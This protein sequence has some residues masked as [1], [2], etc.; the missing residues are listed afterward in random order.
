MF[1]SEGSRI[2]RATQKHPV[3]KNFKERKETKRRHGVE[4]SGKCVTSTAEQLGDPEDRAS[5]TYKG[6]GKGEDGSLS[7]MAKGEN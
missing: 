3:L 7:L 2:V 4:H 6:M 1:K 5:R